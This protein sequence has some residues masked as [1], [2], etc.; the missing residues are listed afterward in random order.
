M[1]RVILVMGPAGCGKTTIGRRLAELYDAE[2]V[3]ADDHHSPS[4]IRKMTD[5]IPL[6]DE[7]RAPWLA[8]LGAL[9]EDVLQKEECGIGLV[10]ACSALKRSYREALTAGNQSVAFVYPQVSRASL[11]A[12]LSQRGGH[13]FDPALLDNQLALLEPPEKTCVYDGHLPLEELCGQVRQ[14]L[15]R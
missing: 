13:F 4:S 11:G 10:L 5:G 14:R 8:R 2:F 1:P 12:R 3:D 15:G 6:T 9:I 7:D